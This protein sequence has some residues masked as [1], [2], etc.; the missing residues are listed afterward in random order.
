MIQDSIDEATNLLRKLKTSDEGFLTINFC[1]RM[2]ELVKTL[3]GEK[4]VLHPK[5]PIQLKFLNEE[6]K[7]FGVPHYR[8]TGDA[9]TD[10]YVVLNEED[11]AHGLT[12]HPGERVLVP[13]GVAIALPEGYWGRITHRSSTERRLRLR[14]VEGTIDQGF[15]GALFAQIAN[16]ESWPIKVEHGDRIAQLII[17][18]VI[19]GEFQE[20]TELPS[21]D[22]D[23]R[24][25]GSTGKK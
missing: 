24:G 17:H 25:F 5:V 16:A 19:Q 15:R 14:V 3:A 7:K 20:V 22:R 6:A 4:Q 23:T 1:D 8:Y 2:L 13:T 10:L 18:R 21:S 9:G 11:R 12:V